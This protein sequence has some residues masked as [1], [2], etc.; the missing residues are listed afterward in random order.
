MLRLSK[1]RNVCYDTG[2]AMRITGVI[3]LKDVVEKIWWKHHVT[4]DEVEEALANEPRFRL[5]EKGNVKDEELYAAYSRT[6]AGRYLAVFFVYKR[7]REAL[8][9]TARD[10]D[11]KERTRYAKS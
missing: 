1:A 9:V 10:M 6:N 2:C 7:T 4:T 11:G 3:W 8:V 5:Q